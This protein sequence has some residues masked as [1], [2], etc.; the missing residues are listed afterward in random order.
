MAAHESWLMQVL[1]GKKTPKEN[2][3]HANRL[4]I[5]LERS[6]DVDEA[7]PRAQLQEQHG[8]EWLGQNIG[9]LLTRPN[10]LH[11]HPA[12]LDAILNVVISS[13]NVL[14]SIVE[15]RVLAEHN[16][17][18]VVHFEADV[19][20]ASYLPSVRRAVVPA[21]LSLGVGGSCNVLSLTRAQR[22]YFCFCDC[23]FI[24][25]SPRKNMTP[26]VILH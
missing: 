14:A 12:L 21:I 3:W 13:V 19:A 4:I 11:I 2:A 8:P 9:Q 16:G 1:I 25:F 17:R 5:N 20:L 18:L 7:D 6:D 10:G 23:Q 15:H 24:G 26:D 22:Y